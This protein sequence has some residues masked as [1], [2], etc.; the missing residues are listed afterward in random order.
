MTG[1]VLVWAWNAIV[2]VSRRGETAE[3]EEERKKDQDLLVVSA[4]SFC[5]GVV[6][7]LVA[8]TPAAGYVSAPMAKIL[9][10]AAC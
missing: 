4:T 5:D 10:G 6:C 3:E 1:L 9:W 2:R 7:G 8:I